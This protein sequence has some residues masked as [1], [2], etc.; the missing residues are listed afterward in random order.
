MSEAGGV[1]VRDPGR[2][3]KILAAAVPWE[4]AGR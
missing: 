4:D 1:R 2:R 3:D